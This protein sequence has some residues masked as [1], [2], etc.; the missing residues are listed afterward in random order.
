MAYFGPANEARQ[1]FIDLGFEPE[2][3]QTTADFLV[4]ITDPKARTC[5]NLAAPRTASEFATYF[6]NSPLGKANKEEIARYRSEVVQDQEKRN[7]YIRSAVAEHAKTTRR[8]SPY[9]LSVARQVGAV[10]RRSAHIFWGTL[11][12]KSIHLLY[13]RI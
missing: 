10:L 1:Y 13:V 8:S 9:L 4:S 12:V 5:H 6:S 3:R 2:P 7:A 11:N